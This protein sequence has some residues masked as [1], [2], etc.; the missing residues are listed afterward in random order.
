MRDGRMDADDLLRAVAEALDVE[1]SPE[2]GEQ[3]RQRAGADRAARRQMRRYA[4]AV[5]VSAAAGLVVI[6]VTGRPADVPSPVPARRVETAAESATRGGPA[7]AIAAADLVGTAS[8]PRRA[9]AGRAPH[10]RRRRAPPDPA[11]PFPAAPIV[12][13]RGQLEG[14][15]QLASAVASGRVR[16]GPPLADW[17]ADVQ[18][19]VAPLGVPDPIR[20]PAID[21][22]PIAN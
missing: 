11:R 13:P 18:T 1:P 7:T 5:A 21:I 20:V 19:D 17:A 4:A 15:R 8:V 12:V 6:F 2:F 22:D 3:V 16:I 14:V 10:D 9:D